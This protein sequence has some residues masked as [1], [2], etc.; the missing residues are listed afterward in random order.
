MAGF[1]TGF[2]TAL[3]FHDKAL[4]VIID[5]KIA[6]VFI[7]PLVLGIGLGFLGFFTASY[8]SAL[9]IEHLESYIQFSG[10]FAWLS[11]IL[12]SFLK[13]FFRIL[14]FV[15]FSFVSGY[16]LIILLSP[17][18]SYISE[19]VEG[20]LTGVRK[21]VTISRIIHEAFRGVLVVLRNFAIQTSII[22]LVFLCSFVPIIGQVVGGIFG[23]LFLFFLSAYFYGFSCMDYTLER[24]NMPIWKGASYIS[25]RKGAAVGLGF[26]YSV[27]LLVPIIGGFLASFMIIISTAAACVYI[28]E[29]DKKDTCSVS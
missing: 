6:W 10:W 20:F 14:F 17:L 26:F 11:W 4:R 12:S 21:P 13:V 5:A 27:L 22:I 16:I 29:E 18:L 23:S 8:F 28:V 2:I 25:S 7:I 1:F 15:I 24:R 19:K 3:S 9:L